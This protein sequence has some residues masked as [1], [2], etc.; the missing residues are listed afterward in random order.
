MSIFWG[1][2]KGDIYMY[3]EIMESNLITG[4]TDF[5]VQNR[6][7]WLVSLFEHVITVCL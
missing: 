4:I 1:T 7:A 2:E 6:Y 5:Q 3:L